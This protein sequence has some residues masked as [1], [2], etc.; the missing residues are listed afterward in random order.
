MRVEHVHVVEG[1]QVVIGNVGKGDELGHQGGSLVDIPAPPARPWR[2][3][4]G[5]IAMRKLVIALSLTVALLAGCIIGATASRL[6]VPPVRAGTNPQKWEYKCFDEG[7][8]HSVEA[9]ANKLG[10]VGFELVTGSSDR[11]YN[12]AWCFKRRLP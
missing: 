3:N 12:G 9:K 10:A 7:G 2:H 6:V 8:A 5:R 11:T 4:L 1:G